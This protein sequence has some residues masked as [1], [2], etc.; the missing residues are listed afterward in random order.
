MLHGVAR[1]FKKITFSQERKQ[2]GST[3][4]RQIRI[5][6]EVEAQTHRMTAPP[7]AAPS[8]YGQGACFT[9]RHTFRVLRRVGDSDRKI[10]CNVSG[11]DAL[12][13]LRFYWYRTSGGF[14][15]LAP[16]LS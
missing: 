5:Y 8:Q 4:K 10:D 9:K 11:R 6:A 2:S 1:C 7:G 15:I 12:G 3:V 13:S 16:L 14:S